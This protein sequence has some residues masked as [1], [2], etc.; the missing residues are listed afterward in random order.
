MGLFVWE[1][2][3]ARKSNSWTVSPRVR[4]MFGLQVTFKR[5]NLV[6]EFI[7]TKLSRAESYRT[8]LYRGESCR[9]KDRLSRAY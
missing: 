8:D 4:F 6:L 9:G 2:E 3:V 1:E 7:P 5:T